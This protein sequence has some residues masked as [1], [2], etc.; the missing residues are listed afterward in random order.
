MVTIISFNKGILNKE[1][2]PN[3]FKRTV[4]NIE[5]EVEQEFDID[6]CNIY[7]IVNQVRVGGFCHYRTEQNYS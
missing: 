5:R 7:G 3:Q 4:E 6:I 2:D 1:S